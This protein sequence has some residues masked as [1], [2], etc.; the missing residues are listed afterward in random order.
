MFRLINMSSSCSLSVSL[1][2]CRK[3]WD[4]LLPTGDLLFYCHYQQFLDQHNFVDLNKGKMFIRIMR[5]T[6]STQF[7]GRKGVKKITNYEKQ[8]LTRRSVLSPLSIRL[9]QD[10][11]WSNQSV[12]HITHIGHRLTGPEPPTQFMTIGW[13]TWVK[14][15]THF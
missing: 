2:H 12:S 6:I 13:S 4:S 9:T 1:R 15:R 3:M 14:T 8:I 10:G 5:A 11:V 7:T